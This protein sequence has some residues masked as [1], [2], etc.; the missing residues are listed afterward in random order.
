MV[1]LFLLA[2]LAFGCFMAL[3]LFFPSSTHTA[4][5]AWGHA[6][7]WIA[8]GVVGVCWVGYKAIK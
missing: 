6:V 2:V 5:T 1:K 7:P 8:L 3:A 4:F